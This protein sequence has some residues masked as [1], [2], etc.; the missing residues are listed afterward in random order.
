MFCNSPAEK[1]L[2][3]YLSATSEHFHETKLKQAVFEAIKLTMRDSDYKD[4]NE[5]KDPNKEFLSLEDIII[6]QEDEPKQK[7]CIYSLKKYGSNL[8]SLD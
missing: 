7:R 1:L 2:T 4:L 6:L 8:N 3:Q 5:S